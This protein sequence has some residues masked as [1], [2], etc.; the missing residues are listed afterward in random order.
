MRSNAVILLLLAS[1]G[2]LAQRNSRD[3]DKPHHE[4]LSALRPKF[5]VR[6]DSGS[7]HQPHTAAP[8]VEP[9]HTVTQ[10]VDMILDS[11]DEINS[12]RKFISGYTIQVYSGQNREEANNTKKKMIDELDMRADLLYEQPKFRVKTGRYFTS[13]EAQ[14]DLVKIRRAF[15]NAILVPEFI[16]IR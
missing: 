12:M 11:I 4:D 5:E 9:R 14:K 3:K 2:A 13:I 10:K 7:G 6:A 16:P 8:L 1:F 15:P